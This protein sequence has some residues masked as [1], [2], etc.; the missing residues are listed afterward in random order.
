MSNNITADIR[1][2]IVKSWPVIGA[3][4]VFPLPT[5]TC[6]Q[7]QP[8]GRWDGFP[9]TR[10]QGPGA[11]SCSYQCWWGHELKPAATQIEGINSLRIWNILLPQWW[12]LHNIFIML[13]KLIKF[14]LL[15]NHSVI[16][17]WSPPPQL[18]LLASCSKMWTDGV[19]L[20]VVKWD[21]I[22]YYFFNFKQQCLSQTILKIGKRRLVK[23]TF[24]TWFYFCHCVP[25]VK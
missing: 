11:E 10:P 17:L 7:L 19:N 2:I 25:P 18:S 4:P 14:W 24:S 6:Q 3:G 22:L 15:W 8:L 12:H 5:A 9:G 16:T 20:N 13:Y 21:V 23:F 1:D